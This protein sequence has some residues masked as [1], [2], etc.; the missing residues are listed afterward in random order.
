MVHLE[1]ANPLLL[2]P[3][4][5]QEELTSTSTSGPV[6][7]LS[8]DTVEDDDHIAAKHRFEH[9]SFESSVDPK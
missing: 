4:D 3:D 2:K 8:T 9:C 1:A 5:D 7:Y 6:F